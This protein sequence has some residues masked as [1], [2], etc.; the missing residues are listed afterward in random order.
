MSD[1]QFDVGSAGIDLQSSRSGWPADLV[2]KISDQD[3]EWLFYCQK[4]VSTSNYIL[5]EKKRFQ[6]TAHGFEY[7]Q[8]S[9]G[10]EGNR[11]EHSWPSC[12]SRR[13]GEVWNASEY[14]NMRPNLF[15]SS[16]SVPALELKWEE[17]VDSDI[18]VVWWNPQIYIC[19]EADTSS[20]VCLLKLSRSCSKSY[21]IQSLTWRK[22]TTSAP[23][24][25]RQE[26]HRKQLK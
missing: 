8:I 10:H 16:N 24:K 4:K 23:N 1:H 26:T 11:P 2:R 13:F 19:I 14:K 12:S 7:V 22:K 5:V 21:D 15:H 9:G 20:S 3:S 6:S 17:R 25:A 18:P